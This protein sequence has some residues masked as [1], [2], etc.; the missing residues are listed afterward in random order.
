MEAVYVFVST[1]R[2]PS[3]EAMREY[4]EKKY[5]EDGDGIPSAFMTEVDLDRY[6]PSCIEAIHRRTAEP[7]RQL[8]AG[9]SYGDQ[10]VGSLEPHI[11]ASEAICVFSPNRVHRPQDS[12]LSYCG[13]GVDPLRRKKAA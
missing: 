11:D 12:S 8:L 9:A 5:T 10:W 13:M 2:F 7:I 1:G 3:F 4:I 6:E